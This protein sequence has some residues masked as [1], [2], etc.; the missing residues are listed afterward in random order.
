MQGQQTFPAKGQTATI[1]A[2]QAQ[3]PVPGIRLC[4]PGRD[5]ALNGPRIH[6]CGCVPAKL[7]LRILK[8]AS[9][10]TFTCHKILLFFLI[11]FPTIKK[12]ISCSETAG[13][14]ETGGG[15]DVACGPKSAGCYARRVPPSSTSPISPDLQL[16]N[17][18]VWNPLTCKNHDIYILGNLQKYGSLE[19]SK[20][21]S[22][23]PGLTTPPDI[24]V[25]A[26]VNLGAIH[27]ILYSLNKYSLSNTF[28][29][30]AGDSKDSKN[31]VHI[32]QKSTSV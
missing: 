24:R 3:W 18:C 23:W 11:F 4:H 8:S 15:L 27:S 30:A 6:Q 17:F 26:T 32:L 9:H 25:R 19:V 22:L 5:T 10:I 13:Q 28:S 1:S 21:F 7:Y 20:S 2:L 16:Q 12:C 31:G 29:S 14:T